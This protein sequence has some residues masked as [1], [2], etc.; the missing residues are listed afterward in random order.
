MSPVSGSTAAGEC[1]TGF[2]HIDRQRPIAFADAYGAGIV[3][4]SRALR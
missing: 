1:T 2:C 4:L 3:D